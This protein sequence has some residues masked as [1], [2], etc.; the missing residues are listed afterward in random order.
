VAYP[1]KFRPPTS[2]DQIPF[3][4][5]LGYAANLHGVTEET[6]INWKK[7]NGFPI[8]DI[9]GGRRGVKQIFKDAYLEWV[10]KMKGEWAPVER[11]EGGENT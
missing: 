8:V 5:G 1:T 9:G 10:E 4:F 2:A 3:V 11:H 6:L 7:N